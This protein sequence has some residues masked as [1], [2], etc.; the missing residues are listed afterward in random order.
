MSSSC[1]FISGTSLSIISNGSVKYD[2][3]PVFSPEEL[4]KGYR[5]MKSLSHEM[6]PPFTATKAPFNFKGLAYSHLSIDKE[7]TE[8][9]QLISLTSSSTGRG[10]EQ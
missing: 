2:P 10:K 6:D 1:G 5:T 4:G 8:S 7:L 9:N 3:C